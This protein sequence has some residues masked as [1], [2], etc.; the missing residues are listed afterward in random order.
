MAVDYL[1]LDEAAEICSV[2]RNTVRRWISAGLLPARKFG[3][4]RTSPVR[5]SRAALERSGYA[6]GARKGK[7]GA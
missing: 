7:E 6:L 5:I 1:T 4:S 2:H 3:K